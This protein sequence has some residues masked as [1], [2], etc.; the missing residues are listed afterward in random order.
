[1]DIATRKAERTEMQS[2]SRGTVFSKGHRIIAK[3]SKSKHHLP[4]NDEKQGNNI[5]TG[6][7][8]ENCNFSQ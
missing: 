5:L 6:Q 3:G 8:P 1:M 4:S 7:N 2:R